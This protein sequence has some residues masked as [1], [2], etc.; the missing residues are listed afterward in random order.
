MLHVIGEK[1]LLIKKRAM[2][3]DTSTRSTTIHPSS[4]LGCLVILSQISRST[5]RHNNPC[6]VRSHEFQKAMRFIVN[7]GT[8]RHKWHSYNNSL[9]T[10]GCLL[11]VCML[12]IFLKSECWTWNTD[13]K[14]TVLNKNVH[15]RGNVRMICCTTNVKSSYSWCDTGETKFITEITNCFTIRA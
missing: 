10:N 6:S 15:E 14:D 9:P 3:F 7:K 1:W 12:Y 2:S 13:L 11:Q 8:V 5:S 4:P